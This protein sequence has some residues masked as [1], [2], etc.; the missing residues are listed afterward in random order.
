MSQCEKAKSELMLQQALMHSQGH[1]A[2][3]AHMAQAP[4]LRSA[5]PHMFAGQVP[6]L[7]QGVAL[8]LPAMQVRPRP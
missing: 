6:G 5:S 1:F 8:G 2:G 3:A 4:G 7:V